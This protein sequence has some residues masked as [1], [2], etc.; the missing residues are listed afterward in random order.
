[1]FEFSCLIERTKGVLK[2]M[3]QTVG[4]NSA[5]WWQTNHVYSKNC[6]QM[7]KTTVVFVGLLPARYNDISRLNI[8]SR[9]LLH[10]REKEKC[11]PR[12]SS[13][14]V[15]RQF[16]SIY[17]RGSTQSAIQFSFNEDNRSA[18]FS[19]ENEAAQ[20]NDEW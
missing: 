9:G 3:L 2:R 5:G 1:V 11:I 19:N 13:H 12:I 4:L 15:S 8:I 14:V 18:I 16:H 6:R 20:R 17:Q 7:C 10:V